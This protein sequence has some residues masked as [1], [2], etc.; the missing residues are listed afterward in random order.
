MNSEQTFQ[1]WVK[2]ACPGEIRGS[3]FEYHGGSKQPIAHPAFQRWF[4]ACVERGF[5]VPEWP[6]EYGGAGMDKR[7]RLEATLS[8]MG[9]RGLG[10]TGDDFNSEELDATRN[11]LLSK[12]FLIAGGSSEIQRNIIGKRVLGLPD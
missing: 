9:T 3:K 1:D 6:K 4:D 7:E 2:Q 8:M 11:W 10:W 12:G 5:T